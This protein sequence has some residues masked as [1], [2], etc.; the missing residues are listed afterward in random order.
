LA[1]K[2][3]RLENSGIYVIYR[4]DDEFLIMND[5]NVISLIKFVQKLLL[6]SSTAK[7]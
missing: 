3:K 6:E 2:P 5:I 1:L 7:N 4:G